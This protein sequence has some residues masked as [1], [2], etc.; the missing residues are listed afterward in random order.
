[1]PAV[2]EI[3]NEHH[4]AN[5]AVI[6][7]VAGGTVSFAWL[8]ACMSVT[9]LPLEQFL[10]KMWSSGERDHSAHAPVSSPHA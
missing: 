7:A 8:P 5:R 1:M 2:D 6:R 9:E 3:W 4:G 10:A